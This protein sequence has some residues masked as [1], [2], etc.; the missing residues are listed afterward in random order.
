M[1]LPPPAGMVAS[2]RLISPSSRCSRPSRAWLTSISEAQEPGQPL[3]N[4]AD[5]LQEHCG[6]LLEQLSM[7]VPKE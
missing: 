1:R 2:N 3:P 4:L 6:T 7:P 5:F